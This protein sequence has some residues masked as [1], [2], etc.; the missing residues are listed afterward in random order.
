[1]APSPAPP[2]ALSFEQCLILI[3]DSINVSREKSNDIL[4]AQ[5]Q[6]IR[7]FDRHPGRLKL[8]TYWAIV[9]KLVDR[10]HADNPV[11][12]GFRP[13]FEAELFMFTERLECLL[14]Q[15]TFGNADPRQVRWAFCARF[16]VPWAALRIAF[17]LRHHQSGGDMED[18]FIP[19]IKR[20]KI[21][22]CFMRV[23]DAKVRRKNETDNTFAKRL[24]EKK[25][26]GYRADIAR[27]LC[28][29]FRRYRSGE[30]T[31]SGA[32]FQQILAGCPADIAL[33]AQLALALAIDRN[34]QTAKDEFGEAQTL[35]LIKYF[36]LSFAH[37][38][39]LLLR[40]DA[41]LPGDEVQAWGYLQSQTFTGNTPFEAERFHPL[42]DPFLNILAR[43]ISAELQGASRSGELAPIPVT[44]NDFKAGRFPELNHQ[45]LPIPLMQAVQNRDF[46]AA[47]ATSQAIFPTGSAWSRDLPRLASFFAHLGLNAFR[48]EL[49]GGGMIRSE[50]DAMTVLDEAFRL[51]SLDYAKSQG[52]QKTMAAISLLR[53][54]L[55]PHRP[56]K[57]PDRE[58]AR[59]LHSNVVG[60][61][62]DTNREGSAAFLQSLLQW[63][64]DDKP[65]ALRTMRQAANFGRASCGEDWIWLLRYAP[66][67]SEILARK[68][69]QKYFE[70]LAAHDGILHGETAPKTRQLLKEWNSRVGQNTFKLV[71]KPF[72]EVM[73]SPACRPEP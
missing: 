18:W 69:D 37:F 49:S 68:N 7:E 31:A 35:K 55:Q 72:P 60:Y 50:A 65:A 26:A 14:L 33:H 20:G 6:K 15:V 46:G 48:A 64:E 54:I 42:T 66:I 11:F 8:E 51:H 73:I 16:F 12:N 17:K 25:N 22:C 41:E 2:A 58:L 52:K 67:L 53:F 4:N 62:R 21:G 38:R 28:R 45:G 71:F 57:K 39:H 40:L 61:F 27:N 59:Q 1:V 30:V 3:L 10:T 34:V 19:R 13:L 44:K 56:K 9:R 24:S 63:L 36:G 5:K 43:K 32:T 70:K 47:I 23:L 29:D